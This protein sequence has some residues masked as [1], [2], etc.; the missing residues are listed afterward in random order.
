MPNLAAI[1]T[2]STQELRILQTM[3]QRQVNTPLTS[4]CGRLFDAI[5]SIL[6]LRQ[7]TKYE[8]QAAI[9]LEF[10]INGLESDEQ[11]EFEILAPVTADKASPI[12]V[13]WV[14][15]A[16]EILEDIHS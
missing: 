9:E 4:S 16:K 14:A 6:G 2:F 13:D 11:Y 15:T 1:Q 7:Q 8:G 10:V 5:A 3:L 12:I